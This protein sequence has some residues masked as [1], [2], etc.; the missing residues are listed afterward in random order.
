MILGLG[1]AVVFIGSAIRMVVSFVAVLGAGL[2]LREKFFIPFAWLPKA[3][4]QAAIGAVALDTARA[5]DADEA[6]VDL[7]IKVSHTPVFDDYRI[8]RDPIHKISGTLLLEKRKLQ[9]TEDIFS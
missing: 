2:S 1:V 7:G 8:V 5:Q 9:N 3:T 6:T 4:V